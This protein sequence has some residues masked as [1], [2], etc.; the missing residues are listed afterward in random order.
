MLE[1]Y[2]LVFD[3]TL[4]ETLCGY[5]FRLIA[6][7]SPSLA[8]YLLLA[9]V[10]ALDAFLR[11][12]SKDNARLRWLPLLLPLFALLTRPTLWQKLQLVPPWVYLGWSILSDRVT[13]GYDDFRE[14]YSFALKLLLLLVLG[15]FFPMEVRAAALYAIPYLVLMLVFGVCLLRMLREKQNE[16]LRQGLYMAVFV[17]VCAGLTAGRAPQLLL[18]GFGLLYRNVLAP[19]F[20]VL[21]IALAV[22][23]YGFYLVCAWIIAR[24]KG[25]EEP[26]QFDVRGTAEILGLE[27]EYESYTANL[28]WLRILLIVLATALLLFFLWR[29]FRR[30]LGDPRERA[31]AEPW[32]ERRGRS[33]TGG[34]ESKPLP[35]HIRP[36][37][38]RLAVR[39]DYARYLAEC[40]RRGMELPR[41]MTATE[42]SER[43]ADRFP[44]ADPAA[45]AAL[46]APARYC[47]GESVKPED[48]KRSA[49]LLRALKQSKPE[50]AEKTRKKP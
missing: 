33:P 43:S 4:Y 7:E 36:R 25:S 47:S 6:H 18:K 9:A 5:F 11:A 26:L 48:A 13:I 15:G 29:I 44:G 21:A 40:R 42:L 41:G 8:G 46:Y 45:L 1:F 37:D 3:L 24:R 50:G 30:L 16:G 22:I 34:A 2:K 19:V 31:A 38:P 32:S 17:V 27:D 10:P 35:R 28:E 20:F 39:Y 49:E 23:F 14:H 12:R